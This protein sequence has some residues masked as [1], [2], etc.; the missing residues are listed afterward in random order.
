M[1]EWDGG[2]RLSG[3][4]RA[5]AQCHSCSDRVRRTAA[6]GHVRMPPRQSPCV[7]SGLAPAASINVDS[8]GVV[9]AGRGEEGRGA[10]RHMGRIR[11]T[12][13]S[14]GDS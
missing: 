5:A 6:S 9:A 7:L 4:V 14:H 1:G 12:G 3:R 11:H 2:A 13:E 10:V 8:I